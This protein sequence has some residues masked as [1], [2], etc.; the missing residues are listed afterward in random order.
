VLCLLERRARK[1]GYKLLGL[2]LESAGGLRREMGKKERPELRGLKIYLED[3]A[4]S[5]SSC[6]LDFIQR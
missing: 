6:P 5:S 2:R 4:L 1:D 3:D